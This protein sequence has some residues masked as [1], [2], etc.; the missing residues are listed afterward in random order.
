MMG[1]GGKT[2]GETETLDAPS[3]P[4]QLKP[5][6]S[7]PSERSIA[8][9][10]G[11]FVEKLFPVGAPSRDALADS[12][13]GSNTTLARQVTEAS[14]VDPSP[15]S[16]AS[17]RDRR[18]VP[19]SLVTGM[20]EDVESEELQH[21]I[22]LATPV[23]LFQSD[24]LAMFEKWMA[25]APATR[26]ADMAVFTREGGKLNEPILLVAAQHGAVQCIRHLIEVHGSSVHVT[27]TKG[28]TPLHR[29]A[30]ECHLDACQL[31]I[32]HGAL[33]SAET[34]AASGLKQPA[35]QT[36]LHRAAVAAGGGNNK[37]APVIQL[38]LDSGGFPSARDAVQDTPYDA[39]CLAYCASKSVTGLTRPT[40]YEAWAALVGDAEVA[41]EYATT[42]VLGGRSQAVLAGKPVLKPASSPVSPGLNLMPSNLG[43]RPLSIAE[44]TVEVLDISEPA[45]ESAT[46]KELTVKQWKQLVSAS[47]P[48]LGRPRGPRRQM[49]VNT[50]GLEGLSTALPTVSYKSRNIDASYG[51]PVDEGRRAHTPRGRRR[52]LSIATTGD[53]LVYSPGS[54]HS[55]PHFTTDST[56]KLSEPFRARCRLVVWDFD[57]TVLRIHSHGK[58][59][60]A[61]AVA[62]RDLNLDYAD[63]EFFTR[64][65]P[66][67]V[68]ANIKIAIASFGKY[69]VIQAYLDRAFGVTAPSPS[70]SSHRSPTSPLSVT[71]PSSPR[72]VLPTLSS[73]LSPSIHTPSPMIIS[74][75]TPKAPVPGATESAAGAGGM[76]TPIPGSWSRRQ[77]GTSLSFF[78]RD[79]IITPSM[80]GG[81]DGSS[82]RGGKSKPLAMLCQWAGATPSEVLFFDDDLQ[83]VD[84]AKDDGYVHSF[85]T[86]DGFTRD[87][88]VSA[89]SSLYPPGT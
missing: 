68:A 46:A 8:E 45:A 60:R 27:N 35:R 22:G 33:V 32:E 7:G 29:A 19:A 15:R 20:Q 23:T 12:T 14:R 36:P 48:S 85:C 4:P 28:F 6:S 61:E 41:G 82:L 38:L 3:S 47:K 5:L 55:P 34:S 76:C 21:V 42:A 56:P 37:A 1:R 65:V 79:N 81:M 80:V 44:D 75:A 24:N 59:I 54:V 86:P 31:L 10:G 78:G 9:E 71:S 13:G 17:S 30:F 43:I 67:I 50:I 74:P 40:P 58:R 18:V 26:S 73:P 84:L 69:D 49:S 88:W 72:L 11:G 25:H 89:L 70:H 16:R 39:F 62:D 57:K 51:P 64:L 66:A 87:V 52:P 83:N 77:S 2:G 63:L 53:D